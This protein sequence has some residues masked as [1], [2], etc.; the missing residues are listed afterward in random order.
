MNELENIIISYIPS[1]DITNIERK[2]LGTYPRIA[3]KNLMDI[4]A[5]I[6]KKIRGIMN[7]EKVEYMIHMSKYEDS[8]SAISQSPMIELKDKYKNKFIKNMK[9]LEISYFIQLIYKDICDKDYFFVSYIDNIIFKK[10]YD[11]KKGNNVFT[12]ALCNS[13]LFYMLS[14]LLTVVHYTTVGKIVK[15]TLKE[16]YPM[17]SVIFVDV[18]RIYLL[19]S[20][21]LENIEKKLL[22]NNI[23]ILYTYNTNKLLI[24][25]RKWLEYDDND[26]LINYCGFRN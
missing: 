20:S 3:N 25:K 8:L 2:Y 16:I 4:S 23:D 21:E 10:I 14:R 5:D 12:R 7:K 11:I 26:I 24:G 19:D 22:E 9:V 1:L 6:Y 17:D 15:N 18:D 13:V